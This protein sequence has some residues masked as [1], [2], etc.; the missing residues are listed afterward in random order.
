MITLD[1]GKEIHKYFLTGLEL[2]AGATNIFVLFRSENKG[3]GVIAPNSVSIIYK[4]IVGS[5]IC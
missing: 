2:H 3:D 4:S 1:M 5:Q